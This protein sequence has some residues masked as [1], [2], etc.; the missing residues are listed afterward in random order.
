MMINSNTKRGMMI[1]S[2]KKR[3]LMI[4]S[5]KGNVTVAG[6]AA[7][8]STFKT[9]RLKLIGIVSRMQENYVSKELLSTHPSTLAESFGDCLREWLWFLEVHAC[10][11]PRERFAPSR[12]PCGHFV[13]QWFHCDL[14]GRYNNG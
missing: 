4:Y 2:N 1:Y 8:L 14:E 3:G 6:D 5:L 10:C 12:N 7:R 11:P 9:I 13:W